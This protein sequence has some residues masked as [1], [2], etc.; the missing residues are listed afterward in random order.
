MKVSPHFRLTIGLVTLMLSALFLADLFRLLPRSDTHLRE[1][2]KILGESLAVQLSSAAAAGDA[3]QIEAMLEQ[4][5]RRN[6]QVEFAGMVRGDDRWIANFGPPRYLSTEFQD[7]SSLDRLVIPIFERDRQWGEAR[8]V[9][10]QASDW[11]V[12]YLGLPSE[13]LTFAGYL[14]IVC[15]VVFYIYMRKALSELNP[16]RAVPERVN[17]AFNVLAE[18]V[19]ILDERQRIVLANEMIAH[20]LGVET[21]SLVGRSPGDFTWDLSGDG[22]EELPWQTVIRTGQA[23]TGMPLQLHIDDE[24]L[25]FTVNAAPIEDARGHARGV[26][27]TFD[28]VTPLEAKN[29]ELA[30]MLNELSETQRLIEDKNRQLE[31]LATRDPLTG[32]LN[33]RSFLTDYKALFNRAQQEGSALSVLMIDIDHFKRVNDNHGHVVGDEVIKTVASALQQRFAGHSSVARYGGEEFI[34]ALPGVDIAQGYS[35]AEA[36]RAFI[37]GM[38]ES[39]PF[40]VDSLTVSIGIAELTNEVADQVALISQA[41]QALYQ[42]KQTGRNRVCKYDSTYEAAGAAPGREHDVEEGDQDGSTA[43]VRK[44]QSQLKG[45]HEVVQKQAAEMTHRAMHDDLTGLPNRFLLQDRLTQAMALSDRNDHYAAVVSIGLSSYREI[46]DLHGHEVA[47][48]MIRGAAQRI[49]TVVRSVDTVGAH[50]NDQALTFSRIAE[51]ELALLIVDVDS[52]ESLPKILDRVTETLEQPFTV[53][54]GNIANAVSCGVAIYPND[55]K[56]A[57]LLIRNASLARRHAQRRGSRSGTAYFSRDIDTMATKHARIATELRNAIVNGDLE[58]AYQPKIDSVTKHVT[59][60]EA[61][62]RWNHFEFGRVSPGEFIKI[63]ESI[64]VIDQLTDWIWSQ[65]CDDISAGHLSGLRVSINVSA[66]EL[67][68]IATAARLLNIVRSKG[69]DPRRVE[70]E[71]TESSILDNYDLARKILTKLQDAG[72]LVVLDDFGTAYSSLNLLLE[73][74]VDVIKIDRCFVS[75][76]E[77]APDNRAVVQAIIAMAKTMGKRVV[78]EGVETVNERDCLIRL[79]CREMQGFLY[80]KPL[81]RAALRDFIRA[82]G[83]MDTSGLAVLRML[84]KSA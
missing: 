11:G 76:L 59:G 14:A 28:D 10:A 63:A 18:G 73:I 79:G 24:R 70:I 5:V 53:H 34:V 77:D 50:F 69:V 13:S 67:H 46:H 38:P 40:P 37:S 61:L 41:D 27:I 21:S 17:A 19:V 68:D 3:D 31:L 49:E 82:H 84:E 51:N 9:F 44:L 8:I 71:I 56:V 4:I 60:V 65:V 1:S 57:E 66:L 30:A 81:D 52:L 54:G 74:P 80:S 58:V 48:D 29:V 35:Y 16:S 2:R 72:L 78:A 6:E 43:V 75:Q 55:G 64:G 62:A 47:E 33:R 39:G 15:L 45:M 7:A 32:C 42:A 83:E 22:L 23:V 25:S 20:R 26:L 12:R 36:L